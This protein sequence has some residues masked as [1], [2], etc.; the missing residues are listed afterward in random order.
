MESK[1]IRLPVTFA[2]ALT[3]MKTGQI[4]ISHRKGIGQ[5]VYVN[6]H[7]CNT[8]TNICVRPTYMRAFVKDMMLFWCINVVREGPVS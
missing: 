3:V 2:G 4:P 6:K 5:D 7:I 1:I 8:E